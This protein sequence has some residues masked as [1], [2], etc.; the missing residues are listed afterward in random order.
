VLVKVGFLSL[1]PN[2]AVGGG[3]AAGV[4]TIIPCGR[5]GRRHEFN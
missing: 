5:E 3:N 1:I 2:G 4:G